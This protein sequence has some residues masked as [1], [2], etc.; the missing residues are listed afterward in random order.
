[1]RA[2]IDTNTFISGLLGS[3]TCRKIF[4]FLKEKMFSLDISE[5]LFEEL[6][7]VIQ[8]PKL[9]PL[10]NNEE[11]KEIISFIK[12]QAIF[13]KPKEKVNI[14][15]DTKDNKI[16]ECALEAKSDCIVSGDKDL[17]VLKSF[18]RI[19]VITSKEFITRLTK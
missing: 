4:L 8:R 14:C 11:R 17:L 2:V 7:F 16:L 19:P 13:I 1:M 15:R 9:R 6:K 10:I 18:R 3:R 12:H 5:V